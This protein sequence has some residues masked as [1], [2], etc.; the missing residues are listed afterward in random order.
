MPD[1][2]RHRASGAGDSDF[3]HALDAQR[4]HVRVNFLDQDRFVRERTPADMNAA[5]AVRGL[6]Q[7]PPRPARNETRSQFLAR[8][9]RAAA[10]SGLTGSASDAN[11][12]A[13]A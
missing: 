7:S 3:A 4:I 10:S 9:A 11:P 12:T 13:L 6:A 5:R 8:N 1:R 2:I